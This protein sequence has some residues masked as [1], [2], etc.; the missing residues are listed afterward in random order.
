MRA[1]AA[2]EGVAGRGEAGPQRLVG[3][4][5]D[6]ADRLPLLDDRLQP[7]AGGLPGGRLGGDL[8][9]LGGERLLAGDLGRPARRPSPRATRRRRS[10]R[11]R[12]SRGPVRPGP[13]RSP[14]AA[15]VGDRLGQPLRLVLDLGRI[16]GVRLQPRLEQRHLGGQ[17]VEAPSVVGQP[18]RRLAGLPRADGALAV[19]G[20]HVDGAVVVDP[21]PLGGIARRER[22]DRLGR[23]GRR[24]VRWRVG[25]ARGRAGR[26]TGRAG[27]GPRRRGVGRR[28]GRLAAAGVVRRSGRRL[29]ASAGD[30][31]R[32]GAGVGGHGL[33]G[34]SPPGPRRAAASVAAP[35]AGTVR[36]R[37]LGGA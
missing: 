19:G 11:C 2:T 30:G 35:S 33:A 31:S 18:G 5:V 1:A 26:G 22:L 12:P 13:S 21:A 16:A 29:P 28:R 14:T 4:A 34:A 15:A 3:L 10:R 27:T 24:R 17:V 32:R 9:G 37:R 25:R 6:A 23:H 36:G 20:A 8:L 7:V